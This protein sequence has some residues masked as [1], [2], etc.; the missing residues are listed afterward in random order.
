MGGEG[1]MGSWRW[2][3]PSGRTVWSSYES[4]KHQLATAPAHA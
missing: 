3:I 1:K 4:K 2:V